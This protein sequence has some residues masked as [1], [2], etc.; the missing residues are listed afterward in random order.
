[1]VSPI[2]LFGNVC[3]SDR[4]PSEKSYM[5]KLI[6]LTIAIV[7]ALPA[8]AKQS[9]RHQSRHRY[10]RVN[11]MKKKNKPFTVASNKSFN[12]APKIHLVRMIDE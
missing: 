9:Y 8:Y 5:G 4:G 6:T 3:L 11:N 12:Q 1:M 10:A 7:L 2:L